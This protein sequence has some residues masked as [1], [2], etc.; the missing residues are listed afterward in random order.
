VAQVTSGLVWSE[1]QARVSGDSANASAIDAVKVRLPTGTG[2]VAS[3]ASVTDEATARAAA[4]AAAASRTTA[5]E[6]RLPAG[7]GALAKC[8]AV[9][10]LD[11]R[12]TAAEGSPTSQSGQITNLQ[13]NLAAAGGPNLIYNSSFELLASNGA[14]DGWALGGAG[15][16]P[17]R[18]WLPGWQ[19]R[20]MP[21][22]WMRQG[23][24]QG[25]TR[26]STRL[27]PCIP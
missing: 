17:S 18:A 16:G 24:R 22:A 20:N 6:A 11:T 8:A 10:A 26:T 3:E 12:V 5:I 9:T 27:R 14:I 23:W 1:R 21:P 15:T 25:N 2:K 4:D 19:P 7:T 13:N